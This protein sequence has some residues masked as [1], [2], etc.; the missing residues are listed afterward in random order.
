MMG[1]TWKTTKI[2]EET[3]KLGYVLIDE[4]YMLLEVTVTANSQIKLITI[5]DNC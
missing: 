1:K 4:K 3:K 5:S 2:G